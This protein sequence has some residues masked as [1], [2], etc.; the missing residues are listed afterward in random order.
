MGVIDH[1]GIKSTRII[2]LSGEQIITSNS[3]L[4]SNRVHNFKH[5]AQRRVVFKV[6]VTYDTPLEKLRKIPEDIRSIIAEASDTVFDRAHFA[7]FGAYG[8]QIET[9]YY[10]IGSD[11]NKYMD[12]QQRINFQL[13][14]HFQKDGIE[15]A[16]PTQTLHI[17]GPEHPFAP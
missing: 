12:V 16:F 6:E 10:V 5:M 1:I 11:Y 4:T 15:F 13:M 3:N 9:V 17:K 7:L 2:S 8:L 14:E